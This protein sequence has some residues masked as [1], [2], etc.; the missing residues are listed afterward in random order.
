MLNEITL[1]PDA[2]PE[3]RKVGRTVLFAA[4][5]SDKR[6]W[7]AR[8]RFGADQL[9]WRTRALNRGRTTSCGVVNVDGHTESFTLDLTGVH[10]EKGSAANNCKMLITA[11]W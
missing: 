4:S 8:E 5:V 7:L 6:K 9:A 3:P 1:A 2:G 10:R 11:S